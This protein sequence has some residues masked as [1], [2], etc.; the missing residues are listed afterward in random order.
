[1]SF[2]WISVNS[3]INSEL[4][5]GSIVLNQFYINYHVKIILIRSLWIANKPTADGQDRLFTFTLLLYLK[6]SCWTS[7][8]KK[9]ENIK[10]FFIYIVLFDSTYVVHVFRQESFNKRRFISSLNFPEWVRIFT[11]L[12]AFNMNLRSPQL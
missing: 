7:D 12:F 4:W 3:E 1:M 10:D 9:E 11:W 8:D 2:N 5:R 6:P